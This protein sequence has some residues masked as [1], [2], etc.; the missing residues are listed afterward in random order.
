[1][2]RLVFSYTCSTV[3]ASVSGAKARASA[4]VKKLPVSAKP[5]GSPGPQLVIM[6]KPLCGGPLTTL[7]PKGGRCSSPAQ[8][9]ASINH[10]TVPAEQLA[11]YRLMSASNSDSRTWGCSHPAVLSLLSAGARASEGT[12]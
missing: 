12:K 2:S 4:D 9:Q 11:R 3:V 7:L 6:A 1:M 5:L 8:R 10:S